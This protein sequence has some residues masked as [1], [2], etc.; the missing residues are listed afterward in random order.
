MTAKATG[1]VIYLRVSTEKQERSGAGMEAQEAACR[2]LCERLGIPVIGTFKDAAI[3][4]KDGV[5]VRPGLRGVLEAVAANPGAVVVAYSLSRLGR[6]QRLVWNLLDDRGDYALP[7]MSASEPFD[8]TTP[9]GKAMLG[10]LA[11]WAQLES[12]LISER[13]I[14]ALAAVAA[15]GVKLG[16]PT[17]IESTRE[18]DGKKVRF[19]DPDKARVVR[20]V[21]RMYREGGYSH[22]SLADRLN[23]EGVPTARSGHRWH[24]KTVR[25]AIET[26]VPGGDA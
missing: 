15:R 8:T 18:E 21:Q 22:R 9:L 19:V 1:A 16:A 26:M 17:M 23:A 5:D 25:T 20:D 11:V 6:S 7:F 2:A 3:S 10:M 14:D 4:G 13:T 24:P 12:D